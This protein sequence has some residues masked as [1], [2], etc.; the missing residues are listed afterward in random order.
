MEFQ[1]ARVVVPGSDESIRK[2]LN[3]RMLVCCILATASE[4]DVNSFLVNLNVTRVLRLEFGPQ[5]LKLN[6]SLL[7]IVFP[8][9]DV[10]KSTN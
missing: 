2:Y 9:S 3:I 5:Q 6:C 8:G 1:S 10:S 7:N 4:Q